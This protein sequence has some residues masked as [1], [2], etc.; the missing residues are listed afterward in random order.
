MAQIDPRPLRRFKKA[1]GGIGR[2][3]GPHHWE[4]AKKKNAKPIYYYR[5]CGA[6]TIEVFASLKT[7]MSE[8]KRGQAQR[9][10]M[11]FSKWRARRDKE[12]LL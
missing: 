4:S 9:K 1:I 10:C 12:K 3:T 6:P 5:I 7:F 8:P 2:I 11:A